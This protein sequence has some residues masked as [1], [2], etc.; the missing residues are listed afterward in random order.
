MSKGSSVK[1]FQIRVNGEDIKVSCGDKRLLMDVLR[2]DLR[3]IGTKN[4]CTQG[5]CGSCRVILN[6]KAV[7]SCTTPM[8]VADGGDVV[9]IEGIGT[10]ESPYPLQT[11][12][13]EHGACQCGFC[14][15]G[16]IVSAYG[17]LEKNPDPSVEEIKTS[18]EDNVCRCTGYRQ[19]LE[20]IDSV[21]HPE[22][23]SPV[24]RGV[25]RKGR[26]RPLLPSG[27]R[28]GEVLRDGPVCRR[29]VCRRHAVRGRAQKRPSARP[30]PIDR[31]E[32]S[33]GDGRGP[34]RPD[35]Q[36][37]PPQPVRSS[38]APTSPFWRRGRCGAWERP[39]RPSQPK[40]R[41]SPRLH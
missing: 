22:A 8:R 1:Q 11:A 41:T 3:L 16:F 2:D 9:T 12:F 19:I 28:L 26:R 18:L 36:G 10:P 7:N 35:R 34:R 20:A 23:G 29:S 17:L 40:R 6:G 32:R 31:Q 30:D 4:G 38:D 27:R 15:P 39:L 5:Y 13:A 25:E 21:I 14:I 37:R 33:G 24:E